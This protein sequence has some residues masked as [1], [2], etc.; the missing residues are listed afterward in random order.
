[1]INTI[2]KNYSER[3]G[4]LFQ[5]P[6]YRPSLKEVE[7]ELGAGTTKEAAFWVTAGLLRFS[8]LS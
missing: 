1:M 4:F 7:Q 2:S 3:K 6:G 8:Y 5:P